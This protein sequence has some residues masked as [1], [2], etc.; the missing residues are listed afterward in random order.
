MRKRNEKKRDIQ[1]FHWSSFLPDSGTVQGRCLIDGARTD[2]EQAPFDQLGEGADLPRRQPAAQTP[3]TRWSGPT[4]AIARCK[5]AST[6]C[7]RRRTSPTASPS[8]WSATNKSRRAPK[9]L[10]ASTRHEQ[11]NC[12]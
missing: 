8:T 7:E 2:L 9:Q 12:R 11:P 4:V 5:T 1:D 3:P 10:A 6:A